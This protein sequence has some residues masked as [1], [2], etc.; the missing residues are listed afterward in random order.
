MVANPFLEARVRMI[1]GQLV[2]ANIAS[3]SL[4][5]AI[6]A[7]P[8]ES[9]V[10]EAL[11]GAAYVDEDMPLGKDR[12]LL[13]PV[14]LARM[15]ALAE[16]SADDT[17]LDIAA[18][19]GYSTAILAHMAKRVVAIEERAEL[20]EQ[21]RAALKSLAI[22]SAEIVTGALAQGH[23]GAGP[24][25]VIFINGAIEQLPSVIAGQLA[26]GGRLVAALHQS[27]RPGSVSGLAKG[28]LYRKL[29]GQ[30]YCREMF[31][32][33]APLLNGFEEK[34]AFVF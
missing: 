24:Y 15:I 27:S 19:T 3:A 18:G 4:L 23:P 32:I 12:F 28:L 34:S 13:A 8:R 25:Q 10:P 26:E 16:I 22:R 5:D 31:D 29:N 33:S 7:V 21:A 2:P 6:K 11:K 1:E 20:A 17:V 14:A 9:F 30:L